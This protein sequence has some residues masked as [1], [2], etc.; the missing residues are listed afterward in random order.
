M[1][2]ASPLDCAA[3]CYHNEGNAALLELIPARPGLRVLDCGCGAGDNAR[4]LAARGCSVTGITI[5]PVELELASSFC[6]RVCL[7]DLNQGLPE[8]VGTGY[9]IVVMSHVLE[10]LANPSTLLRDAKKALR[11]GGM[12]AVA[13]P[14][15]AFYPLRCRLLLGR[16]EYT[17][18]GVLDS[19]HLRFYTFDSGKRLL[20]ASGYRVLVA[21]ASGNFPLWRL[22]A[23]MPGRLVDRINGTAVRLFPNLFGVQ[24]LYLAHPV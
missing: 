8:M 18:T 2:A 11:E 7:G 20:E 22:R 1:Q 17:E 12:V 4:R 10:H 24:S 15:V 5:S 14:N 19:T 16:F 3:R 21:R 9:D 6:Q 13:L 23:M